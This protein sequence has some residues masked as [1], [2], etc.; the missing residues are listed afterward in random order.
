MITG[1]QSAEKERIAGDLHSGERGLDAE[2]GD[3]VDTLG[4]IHVH[5]RIMYDSCSKMC[6]SAA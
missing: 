3:G 5:A 6:G 4:R 1:L 2:R